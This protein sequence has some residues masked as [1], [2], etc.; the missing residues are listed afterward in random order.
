M[1]MR[2]LVRC[3]ITCPLQAGKAMTWPSRPLSPL[4]YSKQD[5]SLYRNPGLLLG[6]EVFRGLVAGEPVG[7]LPRRV[8]RVIRPL[9]IGFAAL[10][11]VDVRIRLLDACVIDS[12]RPSRACA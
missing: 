1:P 3:S 11:E 10:T 6:K 9:E 5:F 2:S 4:A 7:L 12:V 8:Q